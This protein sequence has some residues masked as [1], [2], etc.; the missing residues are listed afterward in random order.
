MALEKR[1]VFEPGCIVHAKAL[2]FYC[3]ERGRP[4]RGA[5]GTSALCLAGPIVGAVAQAG[6]GS[7]Q[8]LQRFWEG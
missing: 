5:G 2:L 4:A 7:W 8:L 6:N 3:P 1:P